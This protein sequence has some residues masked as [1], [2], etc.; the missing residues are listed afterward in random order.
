MTKEFLINLGITDEKVIDQILT[1]N[2]YDV[3]EAS[4]KHP[5]VMHC[6]PCANFQTVEFDYELDSRDDLP[7]MFDLF[8]TIQETLATIGNTEVKPIAKEDLATDK[9]KNIMDKFGIPYGPRTTK[10][11]AAEKIRKSMSDAE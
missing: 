3:D 10:K 11:E 7:D 5:V 2:M 6:K 9:Q 4:A 1:A 8:Q